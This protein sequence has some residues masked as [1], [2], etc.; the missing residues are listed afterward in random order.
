[1]VGFV[2]SR[3]G[4]IMPLEFAHNGKVR[5]VTISARI[6]VS[7]SDTAVS[8][9]RLGLG[10]I[11][12]PRHRLLPELASGALVEVLADFPPTPT[13]ISLLYPGDRQLAP[14]VRVFIDW[15]VDVLGPQLQPM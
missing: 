6:L 10:L 3:T 14:R 4:R 13:P 8:A 11:Q 2:S 7:N 1:M 15:L 12:A 9:A 5:D